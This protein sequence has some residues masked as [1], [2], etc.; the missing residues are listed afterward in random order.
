MGGETLRPSW[1]Q[2]FIELARLVAT[3]ST[4][5]RKQVGCVLVRDKRI[6]STGYAGSP[7]G[8]PHCLDVGC[9][10]NPATGG[11]RR[12]IHAEENALFHVDAWGC[13]AYCTLSPCHACFEMLVDAGVKRIVYLEEYRIPPRLDHPSVV[14]ERFIM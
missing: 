3:R 14:V 10:I 2:Y 9:D 6:I 1:D 11:C 12:T 8:A 5:N 4:C 7:P 13:T